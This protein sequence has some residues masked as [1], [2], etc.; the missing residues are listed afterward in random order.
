M[1]QPTDIVGGIDDGFSRQIHFVKRKIC[2]RNATWTGIY[3]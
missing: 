2:W 1:M 3:A